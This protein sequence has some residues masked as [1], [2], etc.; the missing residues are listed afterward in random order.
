MKRK[1]M[2]LIMT[3]IFIVVIILLIAI[4]GQ[5]KKTTESFA[6]PTFKRSSTPIDPTMDYPVVI[7]EGSPCPAPDTGVFSKEPTGE[8]IAFNINANQLI[9][10]NG[11]NSYTNVHKIVGKTFHY[12]KFH[13]LFENKR[14]IELSTR[15]NVIMFRTSSGPFSVAHKLRPDDEFKLS[16]YTGDANPIETQI[17]LCPSKYPKWVDITLT[18]PYIYIT[19]SN[20]SSTGIQSVW[21]KSRVLNT[22]PRNFPSY[23]HASMYFYA[24]KSASI[25]NFTVEGANFA[26]VLHKYP[27]SM[28]ANS[29]TEWTGER[30]VVFEKNWNGPNKQTQVIS[31]NAG[32]AYHLFVVVRNKGGSG[33][34]RITSGMDNLQKAVYFAKDTGNDND[35]R[36]IITRLL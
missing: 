32:Y 13:P 14:K 3:I 15:G 2:H 33:W 28:T 10:T 34:V 12:V 4:Y 20:G 36:T 23:I 5:V 35:P 1:N 18:Q 7:Y 16:R 29:P 25:F 8:C 21:P 19:Q 31:L 6:L 22:V 26:C 9:V 30:T 17:I 27:A 24:H 11:S